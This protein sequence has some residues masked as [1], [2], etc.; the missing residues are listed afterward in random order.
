VSAG[1]DGPP[2]PGVERLDCVGATQHPADLQVVVQER[3]ELFPGVVPELDDRRIAPVPRFGQLLEGG[4]GGGGVDRGVDRFDVAPQRVPVPFGRQP[5]G[6]C[7]S[8]A[9]YADVGI[10][11][12]MP[13]FGLCRC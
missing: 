7:G 8:S 4:P 5:E 13:N 10:T 1:L 6:C 2:V 11:C 9:L 12:I 3:D